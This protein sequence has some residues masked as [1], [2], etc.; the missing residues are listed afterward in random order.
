MTHAV[1]AAALV[2]VCSVQRMPR[3]LWAVGVTAAVIPDMDVL[4]FHFGVA[5]GD[6]LGHRGITHSLLFAL[7]LASLGVL[8]LRAALPAEQRCRAW[9]FLLL[10]TASHGVL[11]ACTNGGLGVAFWAPFNATRYFFPVRPI[12]VSPIGLRRF[13][14]GQAWPVLRSEFLWVWLPAAALAGNVLLWQR[15]RQTR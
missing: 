13:L 15:T 10:A 11:D 1:V 8:A 12:E 5:Y 14:D 4:G 3:R 9:I 2:P 7:M 6:L